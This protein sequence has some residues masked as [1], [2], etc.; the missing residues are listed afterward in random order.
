[1]YTAIVYL[2]VMQAKDEL[3]ELWR[4]QASQNID[5]HDILVAV[6]DAVISSTNA[7]IKNNH[8]LANFDEYKDV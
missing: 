7:G 1:M 6:E 2:I 3:K 8:P 4:C 5:S